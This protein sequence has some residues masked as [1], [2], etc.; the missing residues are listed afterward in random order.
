MVTS[1]SNLLGQMFADWGG[2]DM[3]RAG[4]V[5]RR[6]RA[7]V[8]GALFFGFSLV[9]H[10]AAGGPVPALGTVLA[11]LVGCLAAAV[12]LERHAA[13]P[14]GTTLALV[15]GQGILHLTLA[16]LGHGSAGSHP[17]HGA[18]SADLALLPGAGLSWWMLVSHTLATVVTVALLK[19][20]LRA[21]ERLW[22]IVAGRLPAERCSIPAMTLP[23]S[24]CA[25]PV[26]AW[27][28][29]RVP[30]PVSRR[31]PPTALLSATC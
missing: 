18:H 15:A 29:R 16:S 22:E 14:V 28:R 27:S 10:A 9:A 13:G 30:G 20:G 1:A 6:L 12:A 24:V 4:A 21:L 3:L 31:G 2:T 7:P 26:W 23:R 19:R 25:D 8:A 11:L 17:A 5:L